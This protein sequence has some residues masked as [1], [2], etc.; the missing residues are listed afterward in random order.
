M[1]YITNH[2]TLVF[3]FCNMIYHRY[4]FRIN[5]ERNTAALVYIY[6]STGNLIELKKIF[7]EASHQHACTNIHIYN[8]PSRC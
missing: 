6:N 2:I 7:H 4:I 5:I 1:F 3:R 8:L